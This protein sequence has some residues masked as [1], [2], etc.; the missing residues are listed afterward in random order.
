MLVNMKSAAEAIRPGIL[1]L[2][3]LVAVSLDG[4]GDLLN[5]ILSDTDSYLRVVRLRDAIE[6]GGWRGGL[7][8]RDNAPFGFYMHWTILFDA[9]ILAV[10]LPII[11]LTDN[12]DLLPVIAGFSGWASIVALVTAVAWS[13]RPYAGKTGALVAWAL[14]AAALPVEAYGAVGRADHHVF[15][16]FLCVL[17]LGLALRA[18]TTQARGLA[19]AAGLAAGFCLWATVETMP[20]VLFGAGFAAMTRIVSRRKVKLVELGL[21]TLLMTAIAL[22][23]DPP[24]SGYFAVEIDRH[25]VVFAVLTAILAAA[26]AMIEAIARLGRQRALGMVVAGLCA[27]VG[28][29]IWIALFPDL[30]RGPEAVLG[31]TLTDLWWNNIKELKPVETP[32]DLV[33]FANVGIAG[34]GFT[35]A[36]AWRSRTTARR[37]GLVFW[38]LAWAFLLAVYVVMTCAHVRFS[39][40]VET[41]G[42][43]SVGLGVGL[44]VEKSGSSGG[45]AGIRALTIA[46][47]VAAAPLMAGLA[48]DS[49]SAL[50]DG[51]EGTGANRTAAEKEGAGFSFG[52][53]EIQEV[54]RYLDDPEFMNSSAPIILSGINEA[55]RILYWTRSRTVAGPYQRNV[56]GL[57]DY[58]AFTM[59]K[60]DVEA[61]AI[62][63]KRGLTH[64]LICPT[65]DPDDLDSPFVFQRALIAGYMPEWMRRVEWPQDT[66]TDLRLFEIVNEKLSPASITGAN[67][68]AISKAPAGSAVS[69]GYTPVGRAD[70]GTR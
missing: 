40:Y 16:V 61:R 7:I 45:S 49:A 4:I 44:L 56:E 57:A 60:T 43:M 19:V 5:G 2:V 35:L 3:M 31:E 38:F 14:V 62:A 46:L 6:H 28:G 26:L 64:V 50:I 54:E 21:A 58:Y 55:P 9:I 1:V 29:A 12:P 20:V 68:A 15:G 36:L 24:A 39:P 47:A 51:T 37:S 59:A 53:C 13:I 66:R 70:R 10:A 48:A 11:R 22:W 23:I 8:D 42:A 34:L 63:A 69:P 67:R 27:V 52:S 25:S 41:F 33:T 30:L 65:I 18:V 32:Q 17:Y